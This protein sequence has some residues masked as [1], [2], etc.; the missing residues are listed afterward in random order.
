VEVLFR[1]ITR[2]RKTGAMRPRPR[3]LYARKSLSRKEREH[4]EEK[5]EHGTSGVAEKEWSGIIS[6]LRS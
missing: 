5:I 1:G 2:P 3:I 4:G 6:E